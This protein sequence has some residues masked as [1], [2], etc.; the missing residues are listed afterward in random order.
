MAQSSAHH[1]TPPFAPL[2]LRDTASE[3]LADSLAKGTITTYK[4]ALGVLQEY[5]A[6][7]KGIV[8]SLPLSTHLVVEFVAYLFL[9]GYQHSSITTYLSAV[10]YVHKLA[11]GPDPTQSFIVKKV[12]AGA[13]RSHNSPNVRLP[14][15]P[16][17]LN[18]ILQALLV[19]EFDNYT[20]ILLRAMILLA[21]FAFLR[22]GEI[23]S[24]PGGIAQHTIQDAEVQLLGADAE[25]K[26]LSIKVCISNYKHS[27]GHPPTELMI[28]RA[29]DPLLCPVLAVWAF[30]TIR[31]N[32][33]GHF[34]MFK[35]GQ[36]VPRSFFASRFMDLISRAG[37]DTARY[38]CHSLRIGAATT[39]AAKG[40]PEATIQRLGRWHSNSFNK[41][42][43]MSS[44]NLGSS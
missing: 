44:F 42:I 33:Q 38:K 29:Q 41:Y 23:T 21:F 18:K 26:P 6:T 30:R 12:L 3:L 7:Q 34:F 22:V 35:T 8:L 39:A 16:D 31:P 25:A 5:L 32:V 10:S 20:K 40:V 27:A 13:R 11:D 36:S 9:K 14:I 19:S 24:T 28:H 2:P 43:R 1:L 37:L 17:I 4:R 15:T